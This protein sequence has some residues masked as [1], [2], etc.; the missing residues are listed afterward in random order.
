[1]SRASGGL[2]AVTRGVCTRLLCSGSGF[3]G[4]AAVS[5]PHTSIL[6]LHSPP[7][8]NEPDVRGLQ[9]YALSGRHRD[10]ADLTLLRLAN[11][12]R[13]N[14]EPMSSRER[15]TI[16]YHTFSIRVENHTQLLLMLSVLTPEETQATFDWL[17]AG[18]NNGWFDKWVFRPFME[19]NLR[20]INGD[21]AQ[22]L[23]E[24]RK[25]QKDLAR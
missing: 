6:P 11:D 16:L 3:C 20:E 17:D 24:Y 4:R 5:T 13:K 22:A 8:G 18:E 19:A 7:G 14:G 21:L 10:E 15:A 12:L 25:L 23:F 9:F 2:S 1:M